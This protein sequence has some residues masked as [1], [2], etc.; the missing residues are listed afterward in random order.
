MVVKKI[1]NIE[2]V[3]KKVIV[4][5]R[6]VDFLKKTQFYIQKMAIVCFSLV[7]S[8]TSLTSAHNLFLQIK[9]K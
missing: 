3:K 7:D 5:N 1:Y 2:I 4:S 8:K 6:T 9:R